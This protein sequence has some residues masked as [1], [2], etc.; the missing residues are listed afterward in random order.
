MRKTGLFFGAVAVALIMLS[1]V[2]A[3]PQANSEP[4]M[5]YL[6]KGNPEDEFNI[7]ELVGY[8]AE[9]YDVVFDSEEGQFLNIGSEMT[10]YSIIAEEIMNFLVDFFYSDE[11]F[12]YWM[13]DELSLLADDILA[14]I[15]DWSDPEELANNI[16]TVVESPEFN[17]LVEDMQTLIEAEPFIQNLLLTYDPIE[18]LDELCEW[19]AELAALVIF[20]LF[21]PIEIWGMNWISELIV[22]WAGA[23]IALPV[24][25]CLGIFAGVLD[26]L[27]FFLFLLFECDSFLDEIFFVDPDIYPILSLVISL[28]L[29]P[30]DAVICAIGVLL[31]FPMTVPLS[32]FMIFQGIF[33]Y[34]FEYWS[35]LAN[36]RT[37][38]L[39]IASSQQ[40]QPVRN[41][42]N[43]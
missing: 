34:L 26:G 39:N 37:S 10:Y 40:T 38:V 18:F 27:L 36:L 11:L 12:N 29:L 33:Y 35:E 14:M 22:V 7:E 6:D 19:L 23:L 3:V 8:Y 32:T 4:L 42:T 25:L 15:T 13:S 21:L 31:I 20:I 17:D 28:F 9:L 43:N 24:A 1:S 30:F 5:D 41:P 16:V 2:T